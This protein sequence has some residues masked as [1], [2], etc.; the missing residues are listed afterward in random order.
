MLLCNFGEHSTL[1]SYVRRYNMGRVFY[2]TATWLRMHTR[3]R[4]RVL[5]LHDACY[6][7]NCL[8]N[9]PPKIST[10]RQI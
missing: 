3:T 1:L 6:V 10:Q 2:H 9:A 8:K 5:G 4:A 7:R